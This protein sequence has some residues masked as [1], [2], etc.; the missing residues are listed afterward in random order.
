MS[1]KL[2]R[3]KFTILNKINL[4]YLLTIFLIFF[5]ILILYGQKNLIFKILNSGVEDF[6]ENYNYQY[7]NLKVSGLSR[8]NYNFVEKKLSNY[9]NTSIFLLPLDKISKELQENNWIRN[10]KI[11]T[12]YKDTLF[13]KIDEYEA[14]GIYS[15]NNKKFYFDK[16]GKIIDEIKNLS[17]KDKKLIVFLGQSSN[18]NAR[19]I[20]EILENINFL[21]K[22]QINNITYVNQRRWDVLL[23]NN[24]KLM[25]SENFPENS[26]RNFIKLE[27][28]LSE[29]D[30]NNI[31]E[32]DLRN[33]DKT[34]I[35][36]NK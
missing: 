33:L 9:L 26:L 16:F 34:L 17:N 6:S 4:M 21:S 10:L 11:K 14:F 7:N 2:N 22:Y 13:I 18:L 24:I 31:Q 23:N 36:F 5:S 3:R 19:F 30:I 27:K 29:A 12:N 8:V 25:L 15:F 1:K 32:I 35:T 28:N 20:I